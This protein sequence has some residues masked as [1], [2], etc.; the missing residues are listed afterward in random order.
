MNMTIQTEAPSTLAIANVA[1]QYA[2]STKLVLQC[3]ADIQPDHWF[4]Q[5]CEASNHL[6][7]VA[8]HILNIRSGVILRLLGNE[9][10]GYWGDLF[11]RGGKLVERSKYPA[12]QEIR[13]AWTKVSADLATAFSNVS[14]KTLAQPAPHSNAPN[15]D[16]T[17]G[18]LIAFF[19]LHE[20][21]H[22]GQLAY[23]R[24]F[25]GYSQLVG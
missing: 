20:A 22:V 1:H 10:A 3:T 9:P 6:M 21:Y 14:E 24:K 23:L 18:G 16:G 4:A 12:P 11:A 7:W 15:F 13:D 17:V 19:A 5:P 2:L 8:G 25:L